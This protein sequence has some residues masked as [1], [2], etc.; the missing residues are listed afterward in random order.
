MCM[1]AYQQDVFDDTHTLYSNCKEKQ[2]G[3]VVDMYEHEA[4]K[5]S[6]ISLTLHILNWSKLLVVKTV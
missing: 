5:Q 4:D 3:H 2:Q 6:N 1:Q